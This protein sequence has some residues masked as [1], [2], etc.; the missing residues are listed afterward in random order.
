MCFGLDSERKDDKIIMSQPW[1]KH[2]H[3]PS[4]GSEML[5]NN[6]LPSASAFVGYFRIYMDILLGGNLFIIPQL[7]AARLPHLQ[8]RGV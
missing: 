5:R 2:V 8:I 6:R 1:S 3:T 7:R 4:I